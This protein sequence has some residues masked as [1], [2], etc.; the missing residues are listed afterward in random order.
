MSG[1]SI[2]APSP[3]DA[4]ALLGI[5]AHY[6]ANTAVSLEIAVPTQAEFAERI[7]STLAR[8]PYLVLEEDGLIRGYAYA[9]PFK[10]RAAYARS[11]EWSIYL[12]PGAR[13][14]GFGRRLYEAMEPRLREAGF[15]NLYACIADPVREDEYLTHASERFH[16][17]LGFTR[18]GTFRGCA[19]KFGRWYNMIDME[20]ILVE[21]GT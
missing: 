15:V 6:V 8:Y 1:V 2:R 10:A 11:C 20:K 16:R 17:R 21:H 7:R 14:R 5:Y 4:A 9:G 12:D 13:G 3:D 18:V 19:C